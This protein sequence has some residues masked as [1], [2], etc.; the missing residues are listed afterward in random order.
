M[1][2]PSRGR[3]EPLAVLTCIFAAEHD[4]PRTEDLRAKPELA[5]PVALEAKQPPE[6]SMLKVGYPRDRGNGE[7]PS[8]EPCC[9]ENY[10]DTVSPELACRRVVQTRE[11]GVAEAP[12]AH[13]VTEGRATNYFD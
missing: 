3:V 13:C 9:L 4:L 6:V 11:H 5:P 8:I 2:S 7:A 12:C 1:R 10:V